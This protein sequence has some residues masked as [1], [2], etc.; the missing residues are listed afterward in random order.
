LYEVVTHPD[1]LDNLLEISLAIE[2]DL[3]VQAD[4][5]SAMGE[6]VSRPLR[7]G[8]SRISSVHRMFAHGRIMIEYEV[9][10]DDKRVLV[11]GFSLLPAPE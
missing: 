3:E 11:H 7:I 6:L 4:F 2:D 10:E 8:R 1:A 9:I 5:E